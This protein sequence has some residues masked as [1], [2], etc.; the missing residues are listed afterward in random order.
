MTCNKCGKE[1]SEGYVFCRH[2]GAEASWR[3]E[4][5]KEKGPKAENPVISEFKILFSKKEQP[6]SEETP[7]PAALKK[8]LKVKPANSEPAA[9]PPVNGVPPV[10][11]TNIKIIPLAV[12]LLGFI[13]A[14]FAQGQMYNGKPGIKS[15][16]ILM[17]LSGAMFVAADII[18]KKQKAREALQPVLTQPDTL[19]KPEISPKLEMLFFLI[20]MAVA[21]FF[22]VYKA[23]T[24]P[25]GF[26]Y[27]EATL[28]EAARSMIKDGTMYGE[29]YPVY[30]PYDIKYSTYL[31]YVIS[32]FFNFFGPG[33][34]QER[35]VLIVCGI[36]GSAAFYFFARSMFGPRVALIAGMLFAAMRWHV[37][38]SR[39]GFYAAFG[40][41]LGIICMYAAW[42]VYKNRRVSDFI[43]FGLA[44]ALVPYGYTPGRMVLAALL[45]FMA[46][47][48]VKDFAFYRDNT[49]K[50]V[51]AAVIFAFAFAPLGSYFIK[52]SKEFM[53]R[54]DQVSILNKKVVDNW[55]HGKLTVKDAVLYTWKTTFLMFNHRGDANPRH[56]LPGYPMLDPY[57]AALA[58]MGLIFA[59][60]HFKRQKY[61]LLLLLFFMTLVPGLFTIET[62]QAHRVVFVAPV[63]IM[64]AAI[65]L[66][67]YFQLTGFN[68]HNM[69]KKSLILIPVIVIA[70]LAV[71]D[72]YRV[73]FKMQA[74]DQSGWEAFNGM[75]RAAAELLIRKGK[76]YTGIIEPRFKGNGFDFLM[77]VNK[78]KNYWIFSE[79]S[80]IPIP[81]PQPGMNYIYILQP[82]QQLTVDGVLSKVYPKGI[83]GMIMDG[84]NGTY[85][86]AYTFEV[87]ADEAF[88]RKDAK[89]KNGLSAEYF[90]DITWTNSRLKRI[91]PMI[92]FRWHISPVYGHFSARWT[93]GIKALQSG[94]Y[95]FQTRS[96]NYNVL[97]IDGVKI[98][99]NFRVDGEFTADG[100]VYLSKGT[101]KI[102]LK[103]YDNVGHPAIALYWQPPWMKNG[104]E[105]VPFDAL[106]PAN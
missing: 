7:K 12:F 51:L 40:V 42:N 2:C 4:A 22:R 14:V 11:A 46:Y 81:N 36:L 96:N 95:R 33:V 71:Y 38:F 83:K 100:T 31:I 24:V 43:L 55:Y 10:N 90:Q 9:V 16:V 102:E 73:Y 80:T 69:F 89:I 60:Y 23:G 32:A 70:A 72:N 41:L 57:T 30:I 6:V 64:L 5:L 15:G 77:S 45:I 67:T 99:E 27:D 66:K 49:K 17:L 78:L 84:A 106:V 85:L 47:L 50:I 88:A 21:V 48:L 39:V 37:T 62:P 29:K 104:E 35:A 53:S 56:N 101:H 79:G 65:P 54:N 58:A 18:R 25:G 59:L 1:N 44:V 93:G 94:N 74:K 91:D 98:L 63:I 8:A 26:F 28:S 97:Y 61:M 105:I 3:P 75:E 76:N 13:F 34:M 20:M 19:I 82:D 86:E 103:Y 52:H 92:R 68:A 87:S